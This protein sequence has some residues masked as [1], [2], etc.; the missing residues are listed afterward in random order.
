M[1]GQFGTDYGLTIDTG[2][3][4]ATVGDN[5]GVS[6]ISTALQ[7]EL[8]DYIGAGTEIYGGATAKS[9]VF[10]RAA[11]GN[12]TSYGGFN[13]VTRLEGQVADAGSPQPGRLSDTS[14]FGDFTNVVGQS[15][16]VRALEEAKSKEADAAMTFLLA[17]QCTSGYFRLNLNKPADATQ[18]CVEGAAGSTA[19]PDVTALA[20]INL[21]ESRATGQNV[22]DALTK[23]GTWLASKQRKSGAF[24]GGTS[25]AV[26]NANSTSVA[27][28]ALGLLKNRDAAMRAATWVRQN[29]PVDKSKCHRR[30]RRTSVPSPTAAPRSATPAPPASPRKPATSGAVRRPRRCRSCSTPR[31]DRGA[32]HHRGTPDRSGR[33]PV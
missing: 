22:K 18:G 12:P 16:A 28:Y 2:L 26:V 1:V 20:V 27:G 21:V 8:A 30:S 23:A 29:Q 5:A 24:R 19:D 7:P 32:P 33:R 15:F 9:A 25:T 14:S 31:S 17:Q 4:L 10:A 3:A 6:T 11:K 13:L